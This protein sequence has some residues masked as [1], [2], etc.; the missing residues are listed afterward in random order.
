MDQPENLVDFSVGVVE[1]A[2]IT[3]GALLGM[4]LIG[5]YKGLPV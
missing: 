3:L 1:G 2:S 4:T 5:Y